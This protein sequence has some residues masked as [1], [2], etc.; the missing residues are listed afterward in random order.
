MPIQFGESFL[1]ASQRGVL[2]S[3]SRRISS[4]GKCFLVPVVPSVH[5]LILWKCLGDLTWVVTHKRQARRH[6]PVSVVPVFIHN[7]R[8]PQ[9]APSAYRHLKHAKR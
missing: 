7:Q 8:K 1:L 4:I 2:T 9:Q 6:M 3:V 5:V